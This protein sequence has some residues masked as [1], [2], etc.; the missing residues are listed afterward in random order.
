[1]AERD[2]AAPEPAFILIAKCERT[3]Q[4]LREYMPELSPNADDASDRYERLRD[5]EFQLA[6]LAERVME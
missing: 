2:T 1:M 4:Q 6:E 5:V 3:L